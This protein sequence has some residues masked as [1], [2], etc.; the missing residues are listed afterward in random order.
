M[1]DNIRK[2]TVQ[3]VKQIQRAATIEVV[4]ETAQAEIGMRVIPIAVKQGESDH[5]LTADR[6]TNS[7]KIAL[8]GDVT[9]STWFDGSKNVS[10]AS[11]VKA[12]TNMELE[13]LLQ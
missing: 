2:V 6:L 1:S 3:S 13:M 4:D 9:A 7:R 11:T 8:T 10:L 12:L 5:A